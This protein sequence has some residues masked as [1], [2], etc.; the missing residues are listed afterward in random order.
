MRV[1]SLVAI[2][3]VAA[4]CGSGGGSSD[5]YDRVD[6]AS[7]VVQEALKDLGS[8]SAE[9]D[10]SGKAIEDA[11]RDL[12]KAEPPGDA[13]RFDAH[14]VEGLH[15]LAATLHQA[16]QAGRDGDFAK[17]DDVLDHLDSSPGLRE[18]QAAERALDG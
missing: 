7:A 11:A 10:A 3:V 6:T 1:L 18:L 9:L 2:A 14:L 12:D 15:Q 17:R 8:S 16:A 4:G 5:Y 13:K